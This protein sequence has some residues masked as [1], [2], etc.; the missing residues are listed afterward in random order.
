[1]D[2]LPTVV[3]LNSSIRVNLQCMWRISYVYVFVYTCFIC[4]CVCLG[5]T[6]YDGTDKNMNQTY[7]TMNDVCTKRPI[8]GRTR[9][10]WYISL[11]HQ[12]L[13]FK[14][15]PLWLFLRVPTTTP[16][17]VSHSV[18]ICQSYSFFS[19]SLFNSHLFY[20]TIFKLNLL[21]LMRKG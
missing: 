4:V 10:D 18:V 14:I 1:M 19:P 2:P 5:V 13:A 15:A 17:P 7:R 21:P 20:Q 3:K 6:L 12:I 16:S 11:S 8:H 9:L